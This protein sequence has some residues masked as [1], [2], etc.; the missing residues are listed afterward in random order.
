MGRPKIK[1]S[2]DKEISKFHLET[3][4]DFWKHQF[5]SED[6]GPN[7]EA[8]CEDC[9]Y[10]KNGKCRDLISPEECIEATATHLTL[11]TF[12]DVIWYKFLSVDRMKTKYRDN[13][14]AIILE[15]A[16]ADSNQRKASGHNN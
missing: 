7:K 15:T 14:L 3:T 5:G 11:I 10:F 1:K 16:E 8:V 6:A 13:G 4:K 12:S 9:R 2:L